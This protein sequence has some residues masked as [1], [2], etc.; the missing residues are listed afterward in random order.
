MGGSN[1]ER[2]NRPKSNTMSVGFSAAFGFVYS[3][4]ATSLAAKL[5]ALHHHTARAV[6]VGG[7]QGE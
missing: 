2:A 5:L 1:E 6:N 3:A 4:V 7:W